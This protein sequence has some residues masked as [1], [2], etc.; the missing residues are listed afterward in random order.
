MSE[1]WHKDRY[2]ECHLPAEFWNLN[3]DDNW[4]SKQ[5]VRGYDLTP[6]QS[7]KK[8]QA[9]TFVKKY[10]N[11]ISY[12]C[13]GKVLKMQTKDGERSQGFHSIIIIGGHESGKSF[14][15]AE[16]AKSAILKGEDVRWYD[17][18]A[19]TNLMLNR[20]YAVEEE[21]NTI[22]KEFESMALIVIDAIEVDKIDDKGRL[23][24]RALARARK[25]SGLP[26]IITCKHD[27]LQANE[28]PLSELINSQY[29]K[30]LVLPSS[31]AAT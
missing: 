10:I 22:I 30:K 27:I 29:A 24:L 18:C 7:K 11:V 19:L 9:V 3:L 20:S 23:A 12:V 16:I 5:D 13:R 14:L 28:H 8:Q 21:Q 2:K 1:K 26:W 31:V 15:A 4:I 6:K 25:S 17:Y